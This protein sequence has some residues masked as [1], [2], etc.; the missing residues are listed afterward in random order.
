MSEIFFG[1]TFTSRRSK[2]LCRLD[3]CYCFFVH[4]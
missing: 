2:P 1:S 3:Y 4:L